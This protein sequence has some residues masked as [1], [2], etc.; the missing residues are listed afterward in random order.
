[1]NHHPPS[2]VGIWIAIISVYIV[3][4]S[5][6]L[7]IRFAV[8]TMPPFLMA[9]IRF[10]ISGSLLYLIRRT[11]G[12]PK[13]TC[14]EWRS[15]SIIGIFLLVGGNGGVVWAE[16]WVVSGVAALLVA[17]APLWMILIDT[18]YPN[19]WKPGPWVILGVILGFVGIFILI[20][21]FQSIRQGDIDL[22][23][24]VVLILASLFWSIGSLYSR[25]AKL[26]ASPLLGTGMEM[27]AGGGG[28]L[29]LGILSGEL[30]QL[31]LASISKESWLGLVYLIVFGSWIG[32]TA[33]TWLL[34]AAPTP[35]VSTYAYVNPIVAVFLG[36]FI[37]EEPLTFRILIATVLVVGSVALIT[38]TQQ[39]ALRSRGTPL[40]SVGKGQMD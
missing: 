10:L 12:D 21:P 1:M 38:I 8:Q 9:G 30:K 22:I 6:Y 24:A 16:Q 23:G 7:A 15:A 37:A 40:Q 18:L 34:R 35:L 5:T 3:W 27:L 39:K 11:W 17:T 14:Q 26:P 25:Q 32:F 29:L 31:S 28:L 33:Y 36:Y 2:A 13:P 20:H 4:G 19:G